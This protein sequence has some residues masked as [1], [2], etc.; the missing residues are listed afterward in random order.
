MSFVE[1]TAW[2]HIIDDDGVAAHWTMTE[3]LLIQLNEAREL[4]KLGNC[5]KSTEVAFDRF[6]SAYQA[7][8]TEEQAVSRPHLPFAYNSRGLAR[9]VRAT[10]LCRANGSDSE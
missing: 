3:D 10:L 4:E 2:L 8:S 6:I 7:R 5:A 1:K 9:L